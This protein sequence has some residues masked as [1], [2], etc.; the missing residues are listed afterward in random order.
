MFLTSNL[1]GLQ[2]PLPPAHHTHQGDETELC[3]KEVPKP[4]YLTDLTVQF[5]IINVDFLPLL[6][7]EFS[8]ENKTVPIEHLNS[9]MKIF[10]AVWDWLGL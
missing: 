10:R 6:R 2:S 1:P 9:Y 3:A 8:Y 5:L 7:K 4:G